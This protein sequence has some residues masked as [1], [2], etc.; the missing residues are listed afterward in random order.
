MISINL[1]KF[2]SYFITL[3]IGVV[4]G[5]FLRGEQKVIQEVVKIEKHTDTLTIETIVENISPAKI[6]YLP[7]PSTDK[8]PQDGNPPYAVLEEVAHWDTS[9]AEG[10]KADIKY[11]TAS[12][13]FKNKFTIP[14]RIIETTEVVTKQVT[15]SELPA[16]EFGIGARL[17][18]EDDV[19]KALPFLS[20]A[21]NN[22]FLFLNYKVGIR[23]LA[24][25]SPTNA[26]K[27]IPEIE[28]M[29]NIP[30]D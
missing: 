16:Y 23:T 26:V 21:A 14:E 12:K 19:V 9:T 8:P 27:I 30:F 20:L 10:F 6:I 25:F 1:K 2:F 28:G 17:Q 29:L 24:E 3:L 4:I 7:F 5:W 18:L 11:Y 13:F 22:K 15:L